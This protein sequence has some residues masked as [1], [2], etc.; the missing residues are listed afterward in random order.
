MK[1]LLLVALALS[2]SLVVAKLPK[3]ATGPTQEEA[4]PE[5]PRIAAEQTKAK[6]G[7]PNVILLDLRPAEQWKYSDQL[8]PTAVHEDPLDVSSW[9]DKYDKERTL[10]VY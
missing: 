1:R 10:I 7:D 4:F 2:V 9:A 6:L 3:G 5:I 8:I